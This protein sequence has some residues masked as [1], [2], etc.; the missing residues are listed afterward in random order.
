MA[1][2]ITVTFEDGTVHV[3]RGAP[4]DI[5]PDQVQARAQK[6]F[7]KAVKAMDGG[8]PPSA[9]VTAPP[10][11]TPSAGPFASSPPEPEGIPFGRQV[12]QTLGNI[13]AGGLRGAA[14]IGSTLME[15]ARTGPQG[16][17]GQPLRTIIP[18]IQ[19]RGSQ[20]SADLQSLGAEP[21][22]LAFKGTK[23]GAEI[24]GTLGV[25]PALAAGARV[26]GAGAPVVAALQSA[27]L[28]RTG[29]ATM[30]SG[31]IARVGGGATTG[32][33]SA[34]LV[35]PE[36]A[37]T[38]AGIGAAL[39]AVLG[40]IG[41]AG[42]AM[43]RA[44]IEPLFRPGIAAE[45]ALLGSLGGESQA[46]I[47]ALRAT[48]QMPTTPG[49]QATMAE[50]LV[51]GGIRNPTVA[52]MEARLGGSTP[53]LNRRALEFAEQ[54]VGALQG[55]IDRINQQLQQQVSVLQPQARVSLEYMRSTL[56]GDLTRAQQQVQ[57]A[58]QAL[59]GGLADV[60]QLTVGGK[61]TAAAQEELEA[62]RGRVSAQYDQ[63]FKLAGAEPVVP[64]AGVV[65][66][67]GI[68]RDQPIIEFKGLAPETAKV[69]ELYGPKVPE[70][71]V[72]TERG[73]W[74]RPPPTEALPPMV[75]LEQAS[76]LGKA[77]NID[78]A[79]LKGS[80]DAASNIARANI[81]KMRS[82]LDEAIASSKLSDE[83]KAAYAAAKQSHATQVA[84]RFYTGTASKMFREGASNVA[85][86]GDEA[87]AKTVL[88]SETG[89]RDILAA[90]G[91]APETRQALTQGVEDLF[92]RAV[93]DPTTR[94]INPQTA[95]KFLQDNARQI[96]AIGGGLR[97]RLEKVQQAA[98]AL[99]EEAAKLKDVSGKVVGRSSGEL[100]DFALQNTRNLATVRGQMSWL[101]KEAMTS[102]FAARAM[103]GVK[104]GRPEESAA[105]LT[106]HADT[107]REALGKRTYDQM[108]RQASFAQ[109]VAKQSDAL[110][111][112]GKDVEGVLFT[113]TQ[114][115]TP[116]QLSDLSLVAKDLERA[117]KTEA[118]A[119]QG[120]KAAA[121]DVSDLG[122]EAA[123]EGAGSARQFPNMM[124]RAMTF[125]RNTWI[126]LEDRIN[127]KAAGELYALMIENPTA[128]VAALERAQLRAAGGERMLGGARAITRT[129]GQA[130]VVAPASQSN[131][132][133]P[134]PVNALAP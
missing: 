107:L 28:G 93:T 127:R 39:P 104:A 14:S 77:L 112:F 123:R 34:G 30:P 48:Q 45:N 126:R 47:N 40:P 117:A 111:K 4:D 57:T 110:K 19:E 23:I 32:G 119:R 81:N 76:A 94:A 125:A 75:T 84:E 132:L 5:T 8:L 13:A 56:M 97:E 114:N 79:A 50:R 101:A 86:L 61:L 95:A 131:A 36:D 91:N 20:L 59:S 16:L 103:A 37:T 62:A 31:A 109:E 15:L 102:E 38:G 25:G 70:K 87:M 11:Q 60:S 121:P 118:L 134:E 7:N 133:A 35:S 108:I 116:A 85:L 10:G 52:A 120:Q 43:Y 26:A 3:Y 2:D 58:Q 98:T 73:I 24:A 124:N 90:I 72:R 92:R 80:T 33:V 51:E 42:G 55:Q 65:E 113:R 18:R 49:F 41:A 27:G 71:A 105:F 88:G 64:F 22:S 44:G 29:A 54:R 66:R 106:K 83:A 53:E 9:S 100:V 68:L 96:D 130:A 122:T 89:A 82:A 115:F 46:A 69:L 78:Y 67:A 12:A 6:D 99:S 1:R 74:R 129:A 21:E 17:G 63:A 128:A